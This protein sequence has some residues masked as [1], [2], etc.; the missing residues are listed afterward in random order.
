MYEVALD[1]AWELFDAHLSGAR[2]ALVCVLSQQELDARSKAALNSSAEALGYGRSACAFAVAE[3]LDQ[4][5]LF[6]LVEA[7]DPLCLVAADQTAALALGRAFR[8][9]VALGKPSRAFGRTCVAFK[10]FPE[11]LE[12]AQDKQVA[13]ALLKKL[14][15]FGER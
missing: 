3:G 7:L 5:A 6:L 8:C 11:M 2:S 13:W 1:E 10:S 14:P 15:S 4:Q 9:D 12:D